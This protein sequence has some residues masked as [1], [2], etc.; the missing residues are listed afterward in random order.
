MASGS[1]AL[2]P[3]DLVRRGCIQVM[4]GRH[5]FGH[6]SIEE[7]LLTGAFTRKDGRAETAAA[8]EMVYNYFPKLRTGAQPGGLHVGRRTA[9]VRHRPRPDGEAEMVLL[10]EPSMGLA[11]QIVEQ[12]F[13]I[14]NDINTKEG[15][16]FLLAEQNTNVALRFAT[17]GYILE[18][19]RIVMDGE[20]K[21]LRENED[22]K[23]FYLGIGGTD[24]KSFRDGKSYKRRKRWLA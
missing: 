11:P 4:E 10:D 9:D 1:T 23:E 24:R 5:C 8:L 12:I 15:V 21:T 22:V 19:G 2:T 3:N 6:L 16:C 17:H 18:N 13:D 7:N 20:A 14:V